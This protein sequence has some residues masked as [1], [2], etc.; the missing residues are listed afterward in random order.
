MSADFLGG[1]DWHIADREYERMESRR[2]RRHAYQRL[3]PAATAL[4]VVDMVPFF[5]DAN[6]HC[7]TAALGID[8]L[9]RQ[10][11]GLG[12]TVA[13]VVPANTQP[14]TNEVEF[15]GP[16]IAHLYAN[17]GG[18]SDP[19]QRIWPGFAVHAEDLVAEK[20]AASAFFPGRCDLHSELQA[21]E[22]D[23]VLIVG[24][25]T[26]VCCESSVRD[27]STLGY[28][29]V[30]VAD[31][32]VG[33][34]GKPGARPSPSSTAPSVTSAPL[35]RWQHYSLE[36]PTTTLELAALRRADEPARSAATPTTDR[37]AADFQEVMGLIEHFGFQPGRPQDPW[38]A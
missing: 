18:A 21:R 7:Q 11:R 16:E 17:T 36:V 29:V 3:D 19:R 30:M 27:A 5:V 20:S 22:I 26:N 2:G 4:V 15:L 24:T 25:V 38:T 35:M 8:D 14:T 10:L 33:G 23:N 32:N 6:P 9:A 37:L 28:R 34:T 1:S 12:G 13:W 31:L